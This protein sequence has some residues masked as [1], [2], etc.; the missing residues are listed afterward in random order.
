LYHFHVDTSAQTCSSP[1]FGAALTGA[2]TNNGGEDDFGFYGCPNPAFSC[3][4]TS[5]ST[6]NFWVKATCHCFNGGTCSTG[7]EYPCNCMAG[8]YGSN[9]QYYTCNGIPN[10][11]TDGN[12]CMGRGTCV[13]YEN[14]LCSGTYGGSNCQFNN[15]YGTS[16]TNPGSSCSE[17]FKRNS[18]ISLP[19]GNGYWIKPGNEIFQAYCDMQNGG[20][21]LIESFSLANNYPGIAPYIMYTSDQPVNQNQ[22]NWAAYRLSLSR[23]TDLKYIISHVRATCNANL[24]LTRDYFI[25][26]T[27]NL[28]LFQV[29]VFKVTLF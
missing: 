8:Y 24:A 7:N 10:N 28:D 20:W 17:I 11:S 2:I 16:Q 18:G 29:Y 5:T 21:T 1:N 4:A 9:C 19:N 22:P 15:T 14:C 23:I 25:F 27:A 26:R 3:A 12:I 13:G 6:S